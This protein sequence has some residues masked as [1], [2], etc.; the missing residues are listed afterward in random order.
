M[1]G[2]EALGK[3]VVE[4]EKGLGIVPGQEEIHQ[5][6]SIIVVQHA[7]I[8]DNIF[9]VDVAAAESHG[10][11]ED[12]EGVAHGSV[13]LLCYHVQGFVIHLH[14]FLVRD[15]PKV[16]HHVGDADAVEV[17]GLAAR[18]DGREHFVLLGGAEYEDGIG[19]RFLQSLEESVERRLAEHVDLVDDIHA[20]VADLRRYLHLLH[21]GLD[22]LDAVVGGG[23]ELVDTIRAA[24]GEGD[25]GL[26]LSARL[27]IC[28]GMHAVDGLGEDARGAGLA[29]PARAAKEIG[30][31]QLPAENGI[32]ERAGYVILSDQG[33][34]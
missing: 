30:V 33:F 15:S 8:A 26:A 14:A 23:V 29:H 16:A 28:S 3:N 25:A 18:K 24:L 12:G 32:L 6:E 11:V 21:Q 27:H 10:L 7:Q 17:V 20:V 34:E 2:V 31:G 19:R 1:Q 22:V 5:L 4:L 9:V 13:R